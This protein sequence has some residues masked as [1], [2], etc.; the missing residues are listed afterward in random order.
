VTN[1]LLSS[2]ADFLQHPVQTRHRVTASMSAGFFMMHEDSEYSSELP[3]FLLRRMQSLDIQEIKV[4]DRSVFRAVEVH[5][6][7]RIR[8]IHSTRHT[9]PQLARPDV[10]RS[11]PRRDL[12]GMDRG[13]AIRQ[14]TGNT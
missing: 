6:T 3:G 11:S 1:A 5:K 2:S 4:I 14:N 9:T 7:Q 8:A 13:D 12:P 10:C